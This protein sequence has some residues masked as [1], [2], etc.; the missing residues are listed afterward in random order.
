MYY[1]DHDNSEFSQYLNRYCTGIVL[2]KE[3]IKKITVSFYLSEAYSNHS[4]RFFIDIDLFNLEK[5]SKED[6]D[7]VN[8]Y[9]YNS[10]NET[11]SQFVSFIYKSQRDHN[12]DIK[13]LEAFIANYSF[14][15]NIFEGFIKNIISERCVLEIKSLDKEPFFNY[16]KEYIRHGNYNEKETSFSKRYFELNHRDF[17][18]DCYYH[19]FLVENATQEPID[20]ETITDKELFDA[21]GGNID[22][23]RR[24]VVEKKIPYTFCDYL[25]VINEI[26]I[27]IPKLKE[28]IQ[29]YI[30]EDSFENIYPKAIL[31]IIK[32]K[33]RIKSDKQILLKQKSKIMGVELNDIIFVEDEWNNDKQYIGITKEI[34]LFGASLKIK[35]VL[36]KNNLS[37]SQLRLKCTEE[38]N[39]K[40][41]LKNEVLQKQNI[42]T[43]LQLTNIFKREGFKNPLFKAQ[44]KRN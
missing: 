30:L 25:N 10:N 29:N 8:Q 5:L 15:K 7:K 32:T 21:S 18:F 33:E 22:D 26:S 38:K 16:I 13:M 17:Y 24:F 37:E 43:K 1:I 40:Y 4:C 23:I 31:H 3:K 34:S 19:K 9:F 35:Y 11:G 6:K 12:I 2:L 14:A 39:V 28:K 36:L 27:H 42:K 20:C 44:K 41:I